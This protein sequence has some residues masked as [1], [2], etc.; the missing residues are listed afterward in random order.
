MTSGM[1]T[2][3][4]RRRS[5]SPRV[6]RRPPAECIRLTACGVANRQ[7]SM[8]G[9][10]RRLR[11]RRWSWSASWSVRP[12]Q[13]GKDFPVSP[14]SAPGRAASAR[15]RHRSRRAEA[16][17]T[18]W[19]CRSSSTNLASFSKASPLV[20]M[21]TR[22]TSG[23]RVASSRISSN[24]GCSSGSPPEMFARRSAFGRE[25]FVQNRAELR[26]R[27]NPRRRRTRRIDANR[28]ARLQRV[29][30]STIRMQRCCS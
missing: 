19:R 12:R 18:T 10:E 29:V 21:L 3:A 11:R 5:F 23:R 9:S 2:T 22:T 16:K 26:D 8:A 30:I 13:A 28:Q 27:Q 17:P 15:R 7:S 20:E 6:Q 14:A 24:C 1:V 25:D 4:A